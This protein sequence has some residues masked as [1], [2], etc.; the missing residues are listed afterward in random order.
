[1]AWWRRKP[2]LAVRILELAREADT[3]LTGHDFYVRL[4]GPWSWK[5]FSPI[6]RVLWDLEE[7]GRLASWW[8]DY[9]G[10]PVA[11]RPDRR[12]VYRIVP[13]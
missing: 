12:R 13:A 5:P 6:Y 10:P 3:P 8:E 11:G 1:M 7:A 2:S 9:P 4:Y